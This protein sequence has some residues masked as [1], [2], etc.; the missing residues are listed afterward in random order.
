MSHFAISILRAIVEM[1]LLCLVGQGMLAVI[2]GS[3]RDR[4]PVYQL[5]KLITRGPRTL[6]ACLLPNGTS[7]GVVSLMTTL[8]L[9]ILWIIL[10]ILR[11]NL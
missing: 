4:N 6:V 5:F 11:K 3:Q 1:L 9:F 10:A 7:N 8:L 2:A